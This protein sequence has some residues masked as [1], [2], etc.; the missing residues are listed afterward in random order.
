MSKTVAF[1]AWWLGCFGAAL[2]IVG[3]ALTPSTFGDGGGGSL[4]LVCARDPCEKNCVA[5]LL[6]CE[7]KCLAT[8]D[9][10]N[11]KDCICNNDIYPGCPCTF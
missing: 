4:L 3:A 9:P 6:Q 2:L 1:I 7:G 11:C 8:V 10:T 5:G